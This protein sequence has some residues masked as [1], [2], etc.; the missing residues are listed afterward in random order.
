MSTYRRYSE[1]FKNEA[2]AFARS[3]GLSIARAAEDLGMSESTLY[4]WVSQAEID[5]GAKEGLT[6]EERKRLA[7]LE[8][9]N[10][11]LKEEREILKKAAAWF[12]R[13]SETR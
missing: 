2:V 10:R 13:E 8:R 5:D 4:R 3:S 11:I 7:Q 9:E 6:T 12:A 1:E